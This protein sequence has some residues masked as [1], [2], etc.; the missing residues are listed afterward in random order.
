VV[1]LAAIR[2]DTAVTQ[3]QMAERLHTTQGAVSQTE[4][5]DD[6]KLSTLVD[7]LAALGATVQITVSVGDRVYEYDPSEGRRR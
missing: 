5:R 1:D 3:M 4:R 2:R 6:L 7:Y